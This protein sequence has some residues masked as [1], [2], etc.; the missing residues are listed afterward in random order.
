MAEV[1]PSNLDQFPDPDVSSIDCLN[2]IPTSLNKIFNLKKK[3]I[4][5][6][7]HLFSQV[8]YSETIPLAF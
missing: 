8:K 6:T 5:T 2:Y 7:Y 3:Y 4:Y 1:I